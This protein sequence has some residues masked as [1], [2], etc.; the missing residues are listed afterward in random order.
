MRI[1]IGVVGI[2]TA[3]ALTMAGCKA[4]RSRNINKPLAFGVFDENGNVL[5][6][7]PQD[8]SG[9]KP[10]NF[11]SNSTVDPQ[12]LNRSVVQGLGL[13]AP[14]VSTEGIEEII[15][16][17]FSHDSNFVAEGWYFYAQLL[18]N[19][20][21][22]KDFQSQKV[23]KCNQMQLT[24]QTLDRNRTYVVKAMFFW[25]SEDQKTTIVWYEGETQPFKPRDQ[26]RT[27]VLQKLKLDQ[28]LNV[29]VEKSEKDKC[30]DREYL[31]NGLRC[32]DGFFG[33]SFVHADNTD[34][35]DS[36]APRDRKCMT[37]GAGGFAVM[38]ECNYSVSQRLKPRLINVQKVPQTFKTLDGE[39]GWFLL[40]FDSG[41]NAQTEYC[42]AAKRAQS[43]D[44]IVVRE[45]C[46]DPASGFPPAHHLWN[47]IPLAPG[48]QAARDS[49]KIVTQFDNSVR[50]LSVPAEVGSV[51]PGPSIRSG[52]P[53]KLTD[54]NS[55]DENILSSQPIQ[56]WGAA[57]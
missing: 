13:T 31:W 12:T 53:I 30:I 5:I 49:F 23:D 52:A 9:F 55:S 46:S 3:I 21:V 27:L 24:L 36:E 56:F 38:Y 25:Q 51:S 16:R 50:C 41:N 22:I 43:G 44:P 35:A 34:Y 33:I 42:L 40:L 20:K 54:C 19:G 11:K 37:I 8:L 28:K 29:D 14:P 7:V 10:A 39:L 57:D 32:L 2:V 45:P 26:N 17:C 47:L 18:S 48:D 1:W 4:N 15:Y 6:N